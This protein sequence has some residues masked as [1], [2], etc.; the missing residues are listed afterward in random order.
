VDIKN[1]NRAIRYRRKAIAEPD[2][3]KAALL[4]KLAEEAERG[5]LCTVDQMHSREERDNRQ[6]GAR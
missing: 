5:V 1:Y 3:W 6:G 2:E 4:R